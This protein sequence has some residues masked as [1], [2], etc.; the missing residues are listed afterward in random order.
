MIFLFIRRRACRQIKERW[1]I[2]KPLADALNS[3]YL[4]S[5]KKLLIQQNFKWIDTEILETLNPLN[6]NVDNDINSEIRAIVFNCL[7]NFGNYP[8]Q[9]SRNSINKISLEVNIN[10]LD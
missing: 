9:N 7:E 1:I 6:K 5:E 4:S 3:E 10:F 2:Y 8:I